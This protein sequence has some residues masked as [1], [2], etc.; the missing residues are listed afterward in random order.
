MALLRSLI[1]TLIVLVVTPLFTLLA[2]AVAPCRPQ[3]RYRV[4]SQ[5]AKLMMVFIR[6]VLGI[7][8]RVIGLEN[9]PAEPVV[10]MSKHMSAWETIAFQAIFPPQA[11]VLKRE[12]FKI[13]FFGWGLAQMPVIAID[14]GSAREALNQV[15]AQGQQR[16]AEGFCVVIFPEGT[17]VAPG[18]QGD[19]KP[20]GALLA[21]KAG[22]RVVP[23]AHN[24]GECWRRNAFIKQPGEIVVS[25]GPVI[26]P[27]GM[28]TQQLNAR[29][30]QWVEG[31]MRRLFP[32]LYPAGSG[33]ALPAA[34]PAVEAR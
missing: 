33:D 2:I 21:R 29:V 20:G 28:S 3:F 12:L 34:S 16:L 10:L 19:Y 6:H 15:V 11:F 13:P 1:Y 26:D 23:V 17:R 27:A 8:H 7:R 4:I 25:V 31:E 5:W 24:A 32:H 18:E 22:V 9:L 30:E 14:R